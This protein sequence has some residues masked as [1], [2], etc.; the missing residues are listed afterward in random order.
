MTDQVTCIHLTLRPAGQ[1][2]KLKPLAA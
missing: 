2:V 1:R